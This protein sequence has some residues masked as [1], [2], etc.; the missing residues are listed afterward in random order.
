MLS[1]ISRSE[2]MVLVT[3]VGE[4]L[5]MK[6][7]EFIYNKSLSECRDCKLKT[8]CFNLEE[9]KKYRI[10]KV[11]DVRHDCKIHEGGVR[12]VEVERVPI[13][14][15]IDSKQA[16]EGSTVTFEL[17]DCKILSCKNYKLC[18]PMSIKDGTKVKVLSIRKDVECEENHKLK[19]V[20]AED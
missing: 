19:E 6:D 5:A 18:H 2:D 15:A 20:L 12:V 16:I 7:V 3:L 11:R 14:I 13:S 17:K 8:V 1:L 9:G 10:V 4:K